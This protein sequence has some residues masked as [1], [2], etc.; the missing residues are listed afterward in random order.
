MLDIYLHS[1]YI[2]RMSY[3]LNRID[4]ALLYAEMYRRTNNFC[5]KVYKQFEYLGY[6]TPAQVEA[7]LR[8]KQSRVTPLQ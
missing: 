3:P 2:V 1:C 5:N 4:E 8:I 6:I 7:V